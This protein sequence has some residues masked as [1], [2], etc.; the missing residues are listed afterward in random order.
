MS[1]SHH[2]IN[3]LQPTNQPFNFQLI[4]VQLLQLLSIIIQ[5]IGGGG[6]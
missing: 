2:P 3:Q 1:L 6:G 4:L 5:P